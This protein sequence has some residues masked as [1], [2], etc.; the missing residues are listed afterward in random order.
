MTVH[1]TLASPVGELTVVTGGGAVTG[2]YF[3]NHWTRPD[4]AG[5]GPRTEDDPVLGAAVRQLTEYFAGGRTEFE[6]ATRADGDEFERAVWAEIT[7]I[8]YGETRTYGALAAALGDP[9]RARDVGAA[10]GRN[11]LSI[12]VAC[13]RVVGR[14][15]KL[16]GYAGGLARKR[17]LLDL[18][19]PPAEDRGQLW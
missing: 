4:R 1:T 11:P 2:L 17:F 13:H 15:G 14:D 12:L 9:S 16:T 19:Q 3:P 18:E 6:V 7:T 8:P 10:V 5:F